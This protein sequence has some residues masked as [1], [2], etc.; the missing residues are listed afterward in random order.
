VSDPERLLD[1]LNPAQ[2]AAATA[3]GPVAILAGAGTGKTRVISHRVAYA[4]ATGAVRPANVLLVTFTERAARE[5]VERVAGLGLT[6]ANRIA[7]RTFH[8][9]A[10]K[11]LSYFWPLRHD[12]RPPPEVLADKWRIVAPLARRLPGGYRFTPTKDLVDEI[13]WA[14]SRR[15]DPAHYETADRA[16]RS[17]PIPEDLFVRVFAD[18]ERIKSREGLVD[19]DD[20]LAL[21]IDLHANDAEAAATVRARYTW[22]SVDEYRTQ[23]RSSNSCSTCGSMTGATCA[24]WATRTRRSTRSRALPPTT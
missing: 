12:G 10:L 4:I 24:W 20:M 23:A 17:P 3:T 14:K 6:G 5:M 15:I 11:Q 8:S 16:G 18:Y 1:G 21:T 9:A 22:F 19:F 13:E 7:A 2:R